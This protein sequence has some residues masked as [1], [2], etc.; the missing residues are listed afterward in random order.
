[1]KA[2]RAIKPIQQAPF[3]RGD[4]VECGGRLVASLRAVAPTTYTDNRF[5][6]YDDAAGIFRP[7]E[8]PALSRAVQGFSGSQIKGDKKPLRLKASDVSGAIQM[9]S[10][11]CADPT[12]F[13]TTKPGI[14]FTD[15]FVEVTPEKIIQHEHSP[16]HRA[17]FSFEFG[18]RHAAQPTQLLEFC[19]QVFRD[20][21]DRAEKIALIQ[22][23][24]GVALLGLATK[25]QRALVFL[26]DGANGKGVMSSVIEQCMPPGSVC[27]IPP[28]D[29]G[30]EY[31]RAELAGKLINIVSELPETDIMDSESWKS[32]VAGDI[33]T[34]REIRQSPFTFKPVAGHIY[35]ANRLPGTTD[36]SHGFWR[37]LVV[38]GWNRIF[39]ESEQN[40]LLA[41]EI[42][43]AERPLIISWALHGAQRTLARGN[44]TMP[45]T[46]D[47]AKDRWRA[48][49]DQVRA[50]IDAWTTPLELDASKY[51]WT[52]AE[53]LYGAY[54]TWAN[55]NGHRSVASNTFGER[56][57]LLGLGSQ[58]DGRAR[59]YPVRLESMG[60]TYGH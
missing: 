3:D 4:H 30:Q 33:M 10:D 31:R 9:A 45:A 12:F 50:F 7:L 13:T 2:V 32:V 59:R 28:Q 53:S 39:A 17:R 25:Y 21:A 40:P 18:F 56:M 24:F 6:Q 58:S 48:Q 42:V 44:Y 55:E 36:Q 34:G 49:A 16:E 14:A 60:G 11:Q 19:A 23:Y 15:C 27:S 22:E 43:L 35:S 46:S 5:Y 41:D 47:G 20:D 57:R 26:G 8:R 37:R 38:L 51:E 52:A 1:M 29:V 54:R